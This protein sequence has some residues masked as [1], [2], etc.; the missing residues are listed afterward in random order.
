MKLA[1]A[2]AF[3]ATAS[4]DVHRVNMRKVSNEDFVR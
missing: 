4:A 3:L 1:L 2:L